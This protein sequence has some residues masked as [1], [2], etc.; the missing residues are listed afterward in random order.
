MSQ[1][2]PTEE[3]TIQTET[4]PFEIFGVRI[5]PLAVYKSTG[6]RFSGCWTIGHIQTGFAIRR[7]MCCEYSASGLANAIKHL[8]WDFKASVGKGGKV[9]IG[10]HNESHI[11]E[12]RK[13]SQNWPERCGRCAPRPRPARKLK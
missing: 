6:E 7:D 8:D 12:A 5:G 9:K 3:I 2:N 13:I 10:R 11:A 1:S 4:G